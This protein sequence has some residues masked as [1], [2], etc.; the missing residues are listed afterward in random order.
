MNFCHYVGVH[1]WEK[2]GEG[3]EETNPMTTGSFESLPIFQFLIFMLEYF[4]CV[5]V[6]EMYKKGSL[7]TGCV[8]VCTSYL[9]TLPLR[10]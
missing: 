9:P 4:F 7:P 8:Y 6:C 5:R 3:G 10:F 2:G 1:Q